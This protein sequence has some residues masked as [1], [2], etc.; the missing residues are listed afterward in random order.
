MNE[1]K[2]AEK[3]ST[4]IDMVDEKYLAEAIEFRPAERKIRHTKLL[5]AALAAVVSVLLIGAGFISA[6]NSIT[7][8]FSNRWENTTGTEMTEEHYETI[9]NLS[10]YIG[11]SDTISGL[12][13]TVDSATV[14]DNQ[15][16]V[17][18]KVEGGEDDYPLLG[19]S[20]YIKSKST[21]NW[22]SGITW[23][24]KDEDGAVYYM[25]NYIYDYVGDP[26]DEEMDCIL[27]VVDSH[28]ETANYWEFEFTLS[29]VPNS[30]IDVIPYGE[31]VTVT[32]NMKDHDATMMS[33][34]EV[35]E[36]ITR[37]VIAI[38][39][40][41]NG[42]KVTYDN[43]TAILS[44]PEYAEYIDSLYSDIDEVFAVMQDGST[45]GVN[46]T[47]YTP[48]AG[49]YTATKEY[50]WEMPISLD[51]IAY[52]RIGETDIPVNSGDAESTGSS[53]QEIGISE[54]QGQN[55]TVT[56]DSAM[57]SRNEMYFLLRIEGESI[58]GKLNPDEHWYFDSCH[59][60]IDNAITANYGTCDLWRYEEDGV[61]YWLWEC[62]YETLSEDVTSINCTLDIGALH[63]NAFFDGDVVFDGSWSIEFT[64][65]IGDIT[66]VNLST[67]IPGITELA[68]TEF[69]VNYIYDYTVSDRENY[70][71][72]NTVAVMKDGT[73]IRST[74]GTGYVE[75]DENGDRLMDYSYSHYYYQWEIPIN[76]DEVDYLYFV[77]G[78]GDFIEGT[79]I[80]VG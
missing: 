61:Y 35:F 4:A 77:D 28:D 13:I 23:Q 21:D 37:D 43:S 30:H 63:S 58:E 20:A 60:N 19:Y 78:A 52:I 76:L 38:D 8:W 1:H 80:E 39:L 74:G 57:A 2:N 67:D 70:P 5:V 79:V 12:T 27:R 45:V 40:S 16:Y 11:K 72:V 54:T 59:F 73:E 31:T 6:G 15:I 49:S 7:D 62:N 29:R 75:R 51:G 34:S 18:L 69:G 48:T 47:S 26:E 56:V 32:V 3:L 64:V 42:M 22:N 10:Q 55:I 53:V 44:N 24:G 50:Y 66:T 46:N 33:Q 65:D 68:I 25:M 71:V 17:L 14:T 41:E 36:E 9:K